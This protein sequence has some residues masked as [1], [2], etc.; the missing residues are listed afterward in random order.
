MSKAEDA[1]MA[2]MRNAARI[3]LTKSPSAIIDAAA[4]EEGGIFVDQ[5]LAVRHVVIDAFATQKRID[6]LQKIFDALCQRLDVLP[7]V[8]RRAGIKVK[9]GYVTKA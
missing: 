2:A 6:E 7:V 4:L 3:V 8:V 1:D 5:S 9:S